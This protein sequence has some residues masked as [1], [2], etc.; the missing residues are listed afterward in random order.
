MSPDK[1]LRA[2]GYVRLS[3]ATDTSTSPERQRRDIARF[4]EARGWET[5]A[6]VEDIDVSATRR[7][8]DRPGI[9][10]L[11][12]IFSRGAADVVVVSRLDR[13]ARN[14]ADVSTLLDEGIAIVSASEAFDTST[15]QGRAMAQVAQ[16][17]AE[18]EAK[19]IG[20]RVSSSR[21]HLPA[22]GRWPGGPTPYGFTTDELPGG[23]GRT[24]VHHPDEAPV[25]RRMVTRAIEG[26]GPSAIARELNADGIP[27]RRG[28]EWNVRTVGRIL[29]HGSLRGYATVKGDK[30]RDEIG[31]PVV[32]WPPLITPEEAR[33]LDAALARTP[34]PGSYGDGGPEPLLQGLALCSSCGSPMTPRHFR[35]PDLAAMYVCQSR[36]RGRLC[37][38][39]QTANAARLEGVAERL[40]LASYGRIPVVETV[41]EATVPDGLPEVLQAIE[42]TTDAMRAPGADVMALAERLVALNGERERLK[43][44][45]HTTTRSKA[46]GELYADLWERSGTVERRELMRGLQAFVIVHPARARGHWNDDR[47]ELVD[48]MAGQLDD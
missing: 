1:P 19:T 43:A 46:T 34:H 22:V 10:E 36:N 21:G 15:A 3:K 42:E 7:R 13:I 17:F 39:P 32:I 5:V 24:L 18:L 30:V 44:L 41:E 29:R 9:H 11:R 45:P 31:L 20:L 4:I 47:V 26:A 37:D 38:R 40:F 48:Y 8:L 6:T 28:V 16:V 23:G 27:S 12:R 2:V 14:V 25:V 35:R 33:Q